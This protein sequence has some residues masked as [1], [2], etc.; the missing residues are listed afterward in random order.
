[1]HSNIVAAKAAKEKAVSRVKRAIKELEQY[2]PP[3][4]PGQDGVVA[5]AE[6]P[7]RA[8]R[9][10]SVVCQQC[11]AE[12]RDLE[13]GDQAGHQCTHQGGDGAGLLVGQAQA[14]PPKPAPRRG[15]RW[16]KAGAG[17]IRHHIEAVEEQI[18][19]LEDATG[20]LAALLDDDDAAKQDEHKDEWID[21]F[22]AVKNKALEEIEW[23]KK[24]QQVNADREYA[25]QVARE[26]RRVDEI[27]VNTPATAPHV[28]VAV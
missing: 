6:P 5:I 11:A 17:V 15:G 10:V 4:D 27:T 9:R 8:A 14:G 20:E 12:I 2:I 16:R 25:L 18:K 19:G 22:V 7:G 13:A 1:M 28:A 24:G 26:Q 23:C 3:D 21:Y